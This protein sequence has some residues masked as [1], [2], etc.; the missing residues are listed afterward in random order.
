MK[1]TPPELIESTPELAQQIEAFRAEHANDALGGVASTVIF[2]DDRIRIWE[3]TLEPGE[4]S[5]WHHHGHDYYL[6][7]L[8]GDRVA[9][10]SK[11]SFQ[12]FGIPETGNT[13]GVAHGSTEW[14]LNVGQKTYREILFELKD[15]GSGQP[16]GE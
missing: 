1:H 14:A 8:S 2:E 15:T 7:I 11:D 12:V 6:A 5:D 4:S 10:V 9:G 13:V 16:D 3:M